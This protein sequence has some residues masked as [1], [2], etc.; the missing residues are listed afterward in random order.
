VNAVMNLKVP[1]IT[2]NFLIAVQLVAFHVVLSSVELVS[3]LVT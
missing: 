3:Y 1:Y 2:G